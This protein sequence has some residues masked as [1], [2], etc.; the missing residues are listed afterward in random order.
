MKIIDLVIEKAPEILFEIDNMP[1]ETASN[2][3]E[4]DISIE[5]VKR[6]VQWDKKS[7]KLKGYEF[8]FMLELAEGK[9]VLTERNKQ[10]ARWNLEKAKKCGF[11]E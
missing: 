1:L 8:V 7:K 4:K 5:L 9:K 2:K 10:L 11:V 3:K 6:I